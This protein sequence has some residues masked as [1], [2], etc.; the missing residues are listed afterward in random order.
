VKL[1]E[2]PGRPG[3]PPPRYGEHGREILAE[4]GFDRA[5]IDGL[6]ASG[7]LKTTNRP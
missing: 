6:L 3:L 4:A 7:V 2:T 1:A 5:A